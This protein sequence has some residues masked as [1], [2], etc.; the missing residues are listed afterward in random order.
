M[1]PPGMVFD[2]VKSRLR[3][4]TV[5]VAAV[6]STRFP[7]AGNV[8]VAV[9]STS[10][11]SAGTTPWTGSGAVAAGIGDDGH[12]DRSD[13]LLLRRHD[14]RRRGEE[15]VGRHEP[16]RGRRAR[17][18]RPPTRSGV[19]APPPAEPDR[20]RGSRP[21]SAAPGHRPAGRLAARRRRAR[22]GRLRA[23][24]GLERR[25]GGGE[26]GRLRV[27]ERLLER[28]RGRGGVG[29]R[30]GRAGGG[31]PWS[32][33]ACAPRVPDARRR[34]RG[35]SHAAPAAP[36]RPPRRGP[37]RRAAAEPA[38]GAS[39]APPVAAARGASS[40]P[41]YSVTVANTGRPAD[42]AR[43]RVAGSAAID[44]QPLLVGH[45]IAGQQSEVDPRR[46]D[47]RSVR[48]DDRDPTAC[49]GP[50]ARG[51]RGDLVV[52]V[53]VDDAVGHR[54]TFIA[55]RTRRSAASSASSV[56]CSSIAW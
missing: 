50:D 23:R 18:T 52:D 7:V 22:G 9:T 54:Q 36:R 24:L 16:G 55:R 43:A 51:R 14:D 47:P 13:G 30:R 46:G 11:S 1:L 32:P 20:P 12:R 35:L 49:R 38:S 19:R 21:R 8:S 53:E 33:S 40:E 34:R 48:Q 15:Q 44:R 29:G 39:P 2:D 45:R 4:R 41:S 10:I 25:G 31:R 28:G 5:P 6:S 27:V 3:N 42:A 17:R 56:V 26:L 37:Q